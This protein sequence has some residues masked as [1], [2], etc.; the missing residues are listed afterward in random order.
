MGDAEK[1]SRVVAP[2]KRKQPRRAR[3]L[4]IQPS[5]SKRLIQLCEDSEIPRS[6]RVAYVCKETGR[7]KQTVSRW[8]HETN[9]G[10]PDL[11]SFALLCFRF[12]VDANWFLGLAPTKQRLP[13]LEKSADQDN[14]DV[15][16]EYWALVENELERLAPGHIAM[17]M[18]GDEMEPRIRNGARLIVDTKVQDWSTNGIYALD[19]KGQ[20][21]VRIIEHRIGEG[22]VLSC[23]NQRYKPTVLKNPGAAKRLGIKILGAI[24]GWHQTTWA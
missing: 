18:R 5:F 4:Q 19:Y 13:T 3:M 14:K 1:K 15:S 6:A 2:H 8:F 17:I 22:I 9:P 12:Q 16:A 21:T 23:E 7:S 11:E 24:K 20:R 10:F